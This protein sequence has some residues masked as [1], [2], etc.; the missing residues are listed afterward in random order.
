MEVKRKCKKCKSTDLTY[1]EKWEVRHW[2]WW[3]WVIGWTVA[4]L[5]FPLGVG[6]IGI[7][8]IIYLI[9]CMFKKKKKS[10]TYTCGE[11][12]YEGKLK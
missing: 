1:E 3:Q 9:Y 12:G 4:I 8:L 5:T 11:C 7:P 2:A 6:F 10:F